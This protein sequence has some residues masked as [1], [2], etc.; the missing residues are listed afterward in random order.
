MSNRHKRIESFEFEVR[1]IS[2]MMTLT[3][4]SSDWSFLEKFFFFQ[5][6]SIFTN[7]EIS[8]RERK[9]WEEI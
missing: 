7:E 1:Q 4:L 3:R 2:T 6:D 9:N 8:R 5:R